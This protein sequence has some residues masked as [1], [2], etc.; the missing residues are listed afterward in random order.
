MKSRIALFAVFAATLPALAADQQGMELT[1]VPFTETG[2]GA[3]HE[4]QV[5]LARHRPWAQ[6]VV[7]PRRGGEVRVMA[8]LSPNTVRLRV[9]SAPPGAEVYINGQLRGYTPTV[10]TDLDPDATR[11][12]EL[13]LKDWAPE[14][15]TLD[16]SQNTDLSIDIRLRR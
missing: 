16:W 4:I 3:R 10:L 9:T 11:S 12:V 1:P 7:V 6:T 13:R 8:F 2:P 14:V 15:R 5:Q